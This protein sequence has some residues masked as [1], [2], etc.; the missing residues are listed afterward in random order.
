MV[1]AELSV[2]AKVYDTDGLTT[3]RSALKVAVR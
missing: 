2:A 3:G 1:K